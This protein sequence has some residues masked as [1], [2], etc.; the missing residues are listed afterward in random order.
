MKRIVSLMLALAALSCGSDVPEVTYG[1]AGSPAVDVQTSQFIAPAAVG[2]T[3]DA[4][5]LNSSFTCINSDSGSALWLS[6]G[7]MDI[8]R[9]Y[10]MS[11]GFCDPN[12][13]SCT[14]FGGSGVSAACLHGTTTWRT[15]HCTSTGCTL[16]LCNSTSCTNQ[17]FATYTSDSNTLFSGPLNGFAS[18]TLRQTD[19]GTP[20]HPI[21]KRYRP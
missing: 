4:L 10:V 1:A 7:P 11:Q 13:W 12:W 2:V 15:N 16:E 8:A 17:G 19:G 20:G 14:F 21:L 6:R 18:V 9:G 5:T 3:Q